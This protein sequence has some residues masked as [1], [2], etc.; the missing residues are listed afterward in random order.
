MVSHMAEGG[1]RQD[2]RHQRQD[3]AAGQVL[4]TL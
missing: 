1:R 2:D 3:V 4:S